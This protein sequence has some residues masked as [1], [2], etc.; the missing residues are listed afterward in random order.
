[1]FRPESP[2]HDR[3]N[4]VPCLETAEAAIYTRVSSREQQQEG[5]SL[6]AQSRLLLD[7]A[8]RHGFRVVRA[9]EDVETA[10]QRGRKQFARMVEYFRCTSSCRTLLVEKTDRISRNFHDAVTL[11][12]LDIAVHF[13]KE[14]QVISRESHSQATLIY[15]F[16][17]VMARHYSNNLREEVKKGMREKA[18]SGVFPGHAPFGY[19]N[20]RGERTIEIDPTSEPIVRRAF[21]LYATGSYSL[22]TIASVLSHEKG[23]RLATSNL[24]WIL[25]NRFY[26]GEFE[27]GGQT[28]QGKHP[29]FITAE[30]FDKVQELLAS[31]NKPEICFKHNLALRGLMRC[32]LCGCTLTGDVQKRKYVYYRCTRAR[33]PCS[34]P[35]FREADIVERLGQ[36]LEALRSLEY[37]TAILASFRISATDAVRREARVRQLREWIDKAYD[38]KLAGHI[39]EEYWQRRVEEWRDEEE[40]LSE[41][42]TGLDPTLRREW[43]N[44]TERTLR[45]ANR[46]LSKYV[47]LDD[48][49]SKADVLRRYASGYVV[50]VDG[51]TPV[52]RRPFD[53]IANRAEVEEW[54]EYLR[55]LSAETRSPVARPTS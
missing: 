3:G 15:G 28:Y 25:R 5:F 42:L 32:A 51:V 38:D 55:S 48:V 34:L 6:F 7:Y 54:S 26:V 18:A 9:F 39:T 49:S 17:L 21:E 33:G 22:K 16:N 36:S 41:R 52:W 14:G 50:D 8:D 12:D 30:I 27:W 20:N 29:T 31:H 35:N 11:E 45:S 46:A 40:Q 53:L 37:M 43:A 10:K 1:M 23:K 24:H 2:Q 44:E 47:S 13:V 4:A 19:R